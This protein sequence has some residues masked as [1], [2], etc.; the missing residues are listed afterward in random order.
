MNVS[1]RGP[2]RDDRLEVLW[3]DGERIF[4][5]EP[6]LKAD[7]KLGNVLIVRLS[8]EH[9]SAVSL[10]RLAHEYALKDELDGAWAVRPLALIRERGRT[11]LVLED[12]A[13][14]PLDGRPSL[15][16]PAAMVQYEAVR[17]PGE[18]PAV[19]QEAKKVTGAQA[20]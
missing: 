20:K 12:P 2:K 13:S 1:S 8:A 18:V 17:E 5:R 15:P 10:D 16:G 19:L 3:E 14:E 7:G 11:M 4:C 6:R 9:P